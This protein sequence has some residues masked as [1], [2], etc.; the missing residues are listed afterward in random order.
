MVEFPPGVETAGSPQPLPE[1]GGPMN[2][3]LKA[4]ERQHVGQYRNWYRLVVD[5]REG[6]SSML[7]NT[8]DTVKEEKIL[9][10]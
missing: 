9:S 5:C 7:T 6:S 10:V 3:I 4:E 2:A 1:A 8:Q